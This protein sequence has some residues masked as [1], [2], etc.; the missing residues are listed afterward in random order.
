MQAL[1]HPPLHRRMLAHAAEWSQ[2]VG[3][4]GALLL[5]LWILY[6]EGIL[7]HYGSNFRWILIVLVLAPTIGWMVGVFF[8]WGFL[9]GP[10]AAR[11]Q[12]W[13]FAVGDRVCILTGPHRYTIARVYEVWAERGQVRVELGP[14]FEE[15]FGDVFCAV[16]VC[17]EEYL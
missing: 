15:N 11:L 1:V 16:A 7:A 12:G 13:P 8:L 17:R 10:I 14:K 6:S 4:I 9:I 5:A 3:A 2:Y